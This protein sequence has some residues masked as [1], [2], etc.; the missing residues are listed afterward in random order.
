MN[1]RLWEPLHLFLGTLVLLAVSKPAHAGLPVGIGVLGD[2]YFRRVWSVRRSST[3]RSW[4]EILARGRGLNFG[5]FSTVSRG[6]PRKPGFA[7]NWSQ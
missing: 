2:G 3:A 6:E 1:P 7:F 5:K 4:V